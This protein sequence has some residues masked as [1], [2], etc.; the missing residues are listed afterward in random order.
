[1]EE[2]SKVALVLSVGS[3]AKRARKGRDSDRFCSVCDVLAFLPSLLAKRPGY[4]RLHSALQVLQDSSFVTEATR[5]HEAQATFC[6]PSR[7]LLLQVLLH[8]RLLSVYVSS[9]P[10]PGGEGLKEERPIVI[11]TA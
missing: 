9:R 11:L 5:V 2:S 8:V 4:T 3:Y 1:M 6:T 7:V 10:S